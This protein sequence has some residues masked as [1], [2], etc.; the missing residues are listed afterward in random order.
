[1]SAVSATGGCV[2]TQDDAAHEQSTRA[3]LE[4]LSAQ[5]KSCLAGVQVLREQQ[6]QLV[7]LQRSPPK[8]VPRCPYV[9][10]RLANNPRPSPPPLTAHI[11]TVCGQALGDLKRQMHELSIAKKKEDTKLQQ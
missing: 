9:P 11:Q 7:R 10:H 1:M 5:S 6:E 8:L 3:K 4:E 2:G